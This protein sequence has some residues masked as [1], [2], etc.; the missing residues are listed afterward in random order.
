MPELRTSR[1]TR[2]E[3]NAAHNGSAG[4]RGSRIIRNPRRLAKSRMRA[5]SVSEKGLRP[6]KTVKAVVW[7]L[8]G[9]SWGTFAN[10]AKWARGSF[11]PTLANAAPARE[12]RR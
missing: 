2:P 9:D 11:A 1:E 7:R 5:S 8:D 12:T 4:E 3:A 6:T 10:T